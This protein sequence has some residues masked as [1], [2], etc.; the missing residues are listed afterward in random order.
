MNPRAVRWYPLARL[1]CVLNLIAAGVY[2]GSFFHAMIHVGLAV[3]FGLWARRL[4]L[5]RGEGM[6]SELPAAVEAL[7]LEL[8]QLR[9]ELGEVQ[10]RLDFTER[11]L[12]Q[13]SEVRDNP[14]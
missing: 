10:E 7:E 4:R 6:G 11:L 13:R 12:A 5:G 1:L 3:A 8:S 9:Q 14:G 2:A